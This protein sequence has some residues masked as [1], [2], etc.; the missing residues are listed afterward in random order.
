MADCNKCYKSNHDVIAEDCSICQKL[1]FQEGI[2]CSL[3]Q[4]AQ[5][6]V[7]DISCFAYKPNLSVIG[8]V[9]KPDLVSQ[10]KEAKPQLSN[11]HKW[12]KA[13]ALQQFD[14][15]SDQIITDL[16]FHICLITRGRQPLFLNG[17]IDLSS[18]FLEAG[19]LFD[20]HLEVLAYGKDH[21]HLFANTSPDYS[22]DTVVNKTLSF[23]V[24]KIRQEYPELFNEKDTLFEMPYFA[25]T[26]A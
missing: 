8:S 13:N 12:L 4:P 18:I 10:E 21:I 23:V 24:P 26:I 22:L 5:N 6:D 7:N 17:D 2:L 9:E 20:G 19:S 15:D 11:R 14:F 25:E 16:N 1:A 3:L